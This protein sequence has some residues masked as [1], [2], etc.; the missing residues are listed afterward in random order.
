V[1]TV[2]HTSLVINRSLGRVQVLGALV[3]LEEAPCAK[4]DDLPGDITNRPDEATPKAIVDTALPGGDQARRAQ[5]FARESL[6]DEGAE[7]PIPA[8]GCE[9]HAETRGRSG[10]K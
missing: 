9:A 10:I 6:R 3:V 4:A 7:H 5:F 8:L 1:E 2:Q